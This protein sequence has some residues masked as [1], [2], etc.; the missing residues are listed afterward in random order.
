MHEKTKVNFQT[1]KKTIESDKIL[2]T[3]ANVGNGV[4][5]LFVLREAFN[6]L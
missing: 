1:L 2:K 5:A 3:V 6:G 4:L